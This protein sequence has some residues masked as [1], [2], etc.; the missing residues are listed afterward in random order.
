MSR[1]VST[2]EDSFFSRRLQLV[3]LPL[4]LFS[5]EINKLHILFL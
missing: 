2:L 1:L 4:P 3:A 5:E